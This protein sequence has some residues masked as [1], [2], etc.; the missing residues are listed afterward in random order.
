MTIVALVLAFLGIVATA[1][2]GWLVHKRTSRLLRRINS[3][4]IARV[5]LKELHQ[6]KD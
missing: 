5:T 3:I 1:I 4:L 2:V 6:M